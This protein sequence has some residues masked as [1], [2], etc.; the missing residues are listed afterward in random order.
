[1]LMLIL[2]SVTQYVPREYL[3][4]LECRNEIMKFR[5]ISDQKL[6]SLM[7]DVGS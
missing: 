3:L 7:K 2:L 6:T 1:M 5:H 4:A